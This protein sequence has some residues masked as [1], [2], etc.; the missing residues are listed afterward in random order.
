VRNHV[1][2]AA[3]RGTG[4]T[5]L[6]GGQTAIFDD[7]SHVLSSKLPLFIGIVALLSFLLL[8]AVFRGVAIPLTAAV[9]NML[10]A[11]AAF[12]VV[13]A[14]EGSSAREAVQSHGHPH[15][16]AAA[17]VPEPTAG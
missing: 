17:P 10:S 7:F 5:V 15:G 9:M 1:V 16:D 8:M 12:G 2:P 4:L 13:T 14:V 11:G 3:E 6:T